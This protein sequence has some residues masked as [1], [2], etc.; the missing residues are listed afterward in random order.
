MNNGHENILYQL[1]FRYFPYWPLFA[2]LLVVSL[3]STLIYVRNITPMYES[4]TTILIKDERKGL[5]DSKMIESLNQLATKKIIENEIEVLHSRSLMNTVVKK[6][7]LY[8]PVTEEGKMVSASAY[9]TSPIKVEVKNPD[10]LVET[11][12]I[13]FQYDHHKELVRIGQQSYPLNTWV[14]TEFGE[15]QFV[16]NTSRGNSSKS[17]YFTLINPKVVTQSINAR[18][19]ISSVNK[20]STVINLKIRDE[21]PSRGEKILDQLV[22]EYN[23]A[24]IED[25]NSL[26]LNTLAFVEERLNF[27]THDL[28]SIEQKIQH[29]KST[30]GAVD[31]GSQGRLFL[32]NVSANDQKLGDISMQLAV[33]K[34]VEQYVSSKDNA[35]V[36]VPSTLGINDPLLSQLLEKLYNLELDHERLR[37]TTAENN[38][39]LVS[40]SDQIYKLKP[41]I[42]ENLRNRIVSLNAGMSNLYHTNGS[43]AS[44]L[45]TIPRKERELVEISREQSI[46]NS[47]Y[48]FLLQKRE[49]AALSHSS[50][51]ADSRVVD[52]AESSLFPVSPNKKLY[53]IIALIGAFVLGV[54]ILSANEIF[55]RTIL[56]RQEVEKFTSIPILAEIS[57]EKLKSSL[58]LAN[59]ERTFIAE[60]F[61]KLRASVLHMAA[62]D[63][64][65][66]ILIT[67]G[68]SGEGKSFVTLNLGLS[69]AI[70]GKKVVV[71]EFDLIHPTIS[72]KL[73]QSHTKGLSDYL[74][75]KAEPE[76]IIKRSEVNENLFLIFSG[77]LPSNPSELIL[78]EK[79]EELL[80]YLADIF[81]YVI[82]DSAPAG[83]SSDAFILSPLCDATLYIIRHKFTPRIMVQRLDENIQTTGLKNIAIIFNGVKSRGF[84]K[85][86]YGFGYGY[87]YGFNYDDAKKSSGTGKVKTSA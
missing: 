65:K 33:L 16:K 53:Y 77:G 86:N 17:F 14:T 9:E 87:G 61:R 27:V 39:V 80:T 5:D 3:G 15:L 58:V 82:V 54:A 81:D 40:I 37:K 84:L 10:S 18:L 55:N 13:Y 25:K 50:M 51:V 59:G 71:V 75:G 67:S 68:I 24:A 4:S 43:Y 73:N 66:K 62:S 57:H 30:K 74:T 72:K 19:L 38:P 78:N 2:V 47:I 76:E 29:Y 46:K 11:G 21:V 52:K 28:D 12:K 8:A 69:L 83:P 20:L 26:A 44:L 48:T 32:E 34:K 85:N 22:S 79:A 35:G 7:L 45:Q 63:K 23:K 64:R 31:V 41:G 36:I 42:L 60:Q 70:T 49:E 1:W 6:L 56:F